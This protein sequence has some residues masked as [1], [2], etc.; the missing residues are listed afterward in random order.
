MKK[1]GLRIF[2]EVA[3]WCI[4]AVLIGVV[5]F[6]TLS[7]SNVNI[8]YKSFL[9]QS[10]SMEPSIMTGDV[11][12]ITAKPNYS[13][14]DVITY[15]DHGKRVVTHR[16][17][18]TTKIGNEEAYVTKG[19]ANQSQDPVPVKKS[20]V[21]GTVVMTIPKLGYLVSFTKTKWGFLFFIVVPAT[22]IIYDEIRK[23]SQELKVSAD[24]T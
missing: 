15:Y 11:I 7:S 14:R 19:D 18:E 10:G 6:V 20:D 4:F 12:L 1:N 3:F 13:D 5:G 8:P 17:L 24:K 9:I 22:I 16:I 23:M 21:I 2:G